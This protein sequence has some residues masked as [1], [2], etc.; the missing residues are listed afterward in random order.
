MVSGCCLTEEVNTEHLYTLTLVM[1]QRTEGVWKWSVYTPT[2]MSLLNVNISVSRGCCALNFR[3]Y[4]PQTI[5]E[6]FITNLM[7]CDVVHFIANLTPLWD[8]DCDSAVYKTTR[9]KYAWV[10]PEF[11]GSCI[12]VRIRTCFLHTIVSLRVWYPIKYNSQMLF[13][14]I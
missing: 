10:W 12:I 6:H 7:F 5:G 13:A 2:N 14:S 3:I 11:Y 8:L 1:L 9:R 4:I